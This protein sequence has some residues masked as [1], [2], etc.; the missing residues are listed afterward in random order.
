MPAVTLTM[1]EAIEAMVRT[2]Q[3]R[4]GRRPANVLISPDQVPALHRELSELDRL[5]DIGTAAELD[6]RVRLGEVSIYGCTVRIDPD[7]P[8]IGRA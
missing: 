5:A 7:A 4:T 8:A 3:E 1:L 2:H 6:R